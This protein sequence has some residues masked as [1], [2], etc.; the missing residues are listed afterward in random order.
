MGAPDGEGGRPRA[1][2]RRS[3]SQRCIFVLDQG[4][5]WA[6]GTIRQLPDEDAIPPSAGHSTVFQQPARLSL[7]DL[8]ISNENNVSA[9]GVLE[10]VA[11]H[12]GSEGG[13]DHDSNCRP[14]FLRAFSAKRFFHGIP[15]VRRLTL[16]FNLPALPTSPQS[17]LKTP[18]RCSPV[19]RFAPSVC[20]HDVTS[21]PKRGLE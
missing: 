11:G 15:R 21:R 20:L 17:R 10:I 19:R 9:E 12:A 2:R 7:R 6:S 5:L 1:P 8:G 16:N 13:T 4:R 3:R 14:H 18:T